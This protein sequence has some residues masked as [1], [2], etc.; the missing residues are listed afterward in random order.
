[1]G[2]VT[3]AIPDDLHRAAVRLAA[4]EGLSLDAWIGR[5]LAQHLSHEADDP[6]EARIRALKERL[7]PVIKGARSWEELQARLMRLG[8]ALR[9]TGG[10]GYALFHHPTGGKIVRASRLGMRHA[11][12]ERQFGRPLPGPGL[13]PGALPQE[14]EEDIVLIEPDW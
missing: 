14:E 6:A 3:L 8:F 11:R 9:G 12:L 10:G 4:A 2:Q 13:R 1:M 7:A 5:V